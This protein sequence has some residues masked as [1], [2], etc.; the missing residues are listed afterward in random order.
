MYMLPQPYVRIIF[1]AD[2]EQ[3]ILSWSNDSERKCD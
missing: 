1:E 3:N 2:A